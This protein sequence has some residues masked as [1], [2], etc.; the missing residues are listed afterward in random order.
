MKGGM[1]ILWQPRVVDLLE[2]RAG[3]FSLLAD[4]Q[5]LGTEIKGTIMNIYGPS[6]FPLK[7]AFVHHLRWLCAMAKEGNWIIGG[8]FNLITS[9]QEKKGGRRMLDKY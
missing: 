4:F 3:H 2:W 1:A 6:A 8:D 5:I 7:Q 9:L